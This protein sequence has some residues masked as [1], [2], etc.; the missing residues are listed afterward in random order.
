MNV[1]QTLILVC[2]LLIDEP[3][4]QRIVRTALRMLLQRREVEIN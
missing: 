2:Y 1:Y 3:I 4:S